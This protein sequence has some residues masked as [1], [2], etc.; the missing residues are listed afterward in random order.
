MEEEPA[1]LYLWHLD[2]DREALARAG[3][4]KVWVDQQKGNAGG[5]LPGALVRCPQKI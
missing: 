3:E 5:N 2:S 4:L 1:V